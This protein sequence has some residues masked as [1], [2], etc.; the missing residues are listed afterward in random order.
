[1]IVN[2]PNAGYKNFTWAVVAGEGGAGGGVEINFK[3]KGCKTVS[4]VKSKDA[5]Y[6][7]TDIVDGVWSE[8][9]ADLEDG[10]LMFSFYGEYC[11]SYPEVKNLTEFNGDLS[12][13]TSARCMFDSC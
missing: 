3:Y 12:S 13:L 6:L 8:S 4:E 5:N 2:A 10:N 11:T 1:L 9:L 7:T